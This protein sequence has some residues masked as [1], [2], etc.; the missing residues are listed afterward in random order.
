MTEQPLSGGLAN[1]G[2]VVRS[3]RYVL[4]PSGPHTPSV[5]ALLRSVRDAG[6]D[7]APEPVGVDDDG[8]ERLVYIDGDV[9]ISPYPAWSQSNR[10]LISIVELV[11]R[12]HRAVA[13]FDADG[14][15]WNEVLA[16]PVG[17]TTICHNDVELSN[18]VFRNGEA[19]ALLDLEFAAPG[20]PIYDLAQLA[21]LCVPIEHEVDQERMGW[22]RAD[23]AARLRL[24]ADTAGLDAGGRADLV[25]AIDDAMDQVEAAARRRFGLGTEQATQLLAATG[26]IEK[27]DRRREWWA[28]QADAV[29][30]AMA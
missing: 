28:R 23:R 25:A 13:G 2:R 29:A 12:F 1:A 15:R 3:G 9:P 18:V 7:G 30:T 11:C 26:G 16:D 20:R 19:V 21:R 27:Y 17:G 8:R 5:H 6:F 24:V 10:A 14:H 4:R 22:R